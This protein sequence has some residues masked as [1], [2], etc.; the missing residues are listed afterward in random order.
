MAPR[1]GGIKSWVLAMLASRG[2]RRVA[3]V[4]PHAADLTP[5]ARVARIMPG[6]DEGTGAAVE[7]RNNHKQAPRLAVNTICRLQSLAQWWVRLN[8]APHTEIRTLPLRFL[9]CLRF[10]PA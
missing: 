2:R 1:A 5:P 6:R 3:P 8:H 7:P 10:L 9:S 4:P